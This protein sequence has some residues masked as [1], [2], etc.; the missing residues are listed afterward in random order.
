MTRVKICGLTRVEDAKAAV[1]AGVDAIGLNFWRGSKR[2]VD[3]TV[4]REI[5]RAIPSTV[6]RVGVFVD[7]PLDEIAAIATT[8]GLDNV[9]LH[10]DEPPELLEQLDGLGY[11]A[12]RL[13][14]ES[15]LARIPSFLVPPDPVFLVD[16]FDPDQPGGTGRVGRWDLAR[17]AT[18]LGR[19]I[20]AGGLT[21]ENVAAALDAVHP[22]A[23][24]TASGVESAPGIKD[25]AR[26]Q[27]F[28]QAV[29][30]WERTTFRRIRESDD[31]V[32]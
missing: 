26:M 25:A 28:V 15:D 23:V 13:H 11:K 24:D 27:A 30:D 31:E 3:V 2:G 32:Q 5:L 18:K 6:L 1:A 16:T 8:L 10:G 22:W 29:R 21:P 4:A 20:L 14:D 12:I 17:Q 19:L 9:Q 7:A